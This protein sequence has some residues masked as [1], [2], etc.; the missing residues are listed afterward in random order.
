M[1]NLLLSI[2]LVLCTSA[3]LDAQTFSD[4]LRY[5][6]LTP[7]GTARSV[8]AGGTLGSLGADFSSIYS[9][10]AGLG[11]YR[12]SEF[13]LSPMFGVA[14]IK[15]QLY[16]GDGN[17]PNKENDTR[18][19]LANFGLV[20]AGRPRNP[21]WSTS[22]FALGFNRLADFNR[23]YTYRG[24]SRGTIL[25]R[26]VEQA[27][28]QGLVPGES[29]VAYNAEALIYDEQ[30]GEYYSDFDGLPDAVVE[31][32]QT[33]IA[34]GSVSELS[35]AF[36]GN[37]D[38]KVLWGLTIGIPFL[39]YSEQK[40]YRES[41]P[42]T[43]QDGNVPYF[44]GLQWQE[45]LTTTGAGINAKLG[46]IVRPSQMV[47]VG[48]A[49][50][51]PTLFG[52]EDNYSTAMFYDYTYQGAALTGTDQS[53][54]GLFNYRLH[55]PWRFLGGA[56]FIFGKIGFI[57]GEIEYLNYSNAKFRYD[58]QYDQ[59]E[60]AVNEDIKSYLSS[61]VNFRLGGE[62]ALDVW[63]ARAGVAILEAPL[64]GDQTIAKQ[65]SAGF[66]GRFD[67]FYFDL[68]YRYSDSKESYVPYVTNTGPEQIVDLDFKYHRFIATLGFRF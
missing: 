60:G 22:N 31:R 13:T 36:A 3:G 11:W 52:L 55:T 14:N 12:Q 1:R 46:I 32:E 34:S 17:P 25:D 59:S 64:E 10:P 9:N 8:G 37:Y 40:T 2:S 54:N 39:N 45:N 53:D 65:F 18:F 49:I 30:A 58:D 5:S 29:E 26:F 56:G 42:G 47:R 44:D 7:F 16:N 20:V 4:A 61:A 50:H 67:G 35:L 41:D 6:Y 63:R 38:E 24:S 68:A 51:T 21:K 57:S 15:S 48:F 27:N 66:G 33:I 23:E 62:V 19:N 28:S 43:G